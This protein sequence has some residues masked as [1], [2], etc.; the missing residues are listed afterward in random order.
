M[1]HFKRILSD[2]KDIADDNLQVCNITSPANYFHVLRRQ[3]LRPFR[4]PL[5]IMTPKSLLRHPMAKSSASEFIEQSHFKR[6]LSDR[7]DIPD[8]KVRRLVLCSGKVAYDLMEKR[9][10]EKLEG[11]SIVRLEQLYPFPGEPLALRLKQMTGLE[12]VV[13]CQEEPKNNGAW[14]FVESRI[15]QALVEAGHQA[16]RPSYAGRDMAASPATGLARR[17]AEQQAALVEL[18]LGIGDK[19]AARRTLKTRRRK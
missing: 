9:A 16:M 3:M 1:S 17:H 11:V 6:I 2:R 5:V 18:A 13:W 14:F 4:K 12:E 10:E 7:L 8:A 15:E 19:D